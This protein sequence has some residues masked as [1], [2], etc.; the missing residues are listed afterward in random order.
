MGTSGSQCTPR[1][2]QGPQTP[3]G[4]PEDLCA[5]QGVLRTPCTPGIPLVWGGGRPRV[6]AAPT[7]AA[8]PGQPR[9]GGTA[10]GTRCPPARG[11]GLGSAPDPGAAPWA[12]PAAAAPSILGS[13]PLLRSRLLTPLPFIPALL[14]LLLRH[15]AGPSVANTTPRAW[16]QVPGA[17]S[18][19]RLSGSRGPSR[20]SRTLP[21]HT[22]PPAPPA[23]PC[24]T[25]CV[26]RDEAPPRAPGATSTPTAPRPLRARGGTSP[27]G[28]WGRGARDTAPL[29]PFQPPPP[30][31]TTAAGGPGALGVTAVIMVSVAGGCRDRRPFLLVQEFGGGCI[32]RSPRSWKRGQA[33]AG[34]AGTAGTGRS[35]SPSRAEAAGGSH[36]PGVAPGHGTATLP[37]SGSAGSTGVPRTTV[38]PHLRLLGSLRLREHHT[39]VPWVT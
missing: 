7:A 10:G 14:L 17:P 24:D 31:G 34:G 20:G 28:A 4:E 12:P 33:G 35:C 29:S 11:R 25:R 6:H 26:P 8:S 19:S 15:R 32:T 23:A 9:R 18:L 1:R 22:P 21:C 3:H 36:T 2:P 13:I 37:S 16:P 30:A 27:G 38:P 5:P 39:C